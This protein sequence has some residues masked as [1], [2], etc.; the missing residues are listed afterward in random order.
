MSLFGGELRVVEPL[1]AHHRRDV[2]EARV[3]ADVAHL[4][5]GSDLLA[6]VD[7]GVGAQLEGGEWIEIF[8]DDPSRQEVG[9]TAFERA[10]AR[11]RENESMRR[12]AGVEQRL[13][14]VEQSQN[15]LRFVDDDEPRLAQPRD[16]AGE[17]PRIFGVGQEFGSSARFTTSAGPSERASVD[18]P[19]WRGPRRST[20]FFVFAIRPRRNL[21]RMR[22]EEGGRR[23]RSAPTHLAGVLHTPLAL[24]KITPV[25][26]HY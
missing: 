9:A 3:A 4:G 22:A 8:E 1:T 14:G 2:E 11:T 23:R 16:A 12:P 19:T 24:A 6:Q 10:R 21:S 17:Q 26:R 13:D 5:V 18:L 25:S 7:V 15:T 20:L